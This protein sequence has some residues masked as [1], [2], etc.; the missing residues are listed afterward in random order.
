MKFIYVLEDDERIQKDLFDAL[1]SID[2]GLEIRFFHSLS[3]FHDWLKLAITDGP[4][5]L[6]LGG[7]RLKSDANA[8][9]QSANTHELRLVIAKNEFLGV[10]NMGL[11][12]R[13]RDFFLRKK[14]CSPQE[15]T[16]LVLTAFDSPDFDIRLAEQRIINNVIFKPFDKLILR[17]HLE[18][19]LTGH[20]PVS[21]TAVASMQISST[22]EM[23]KDIRCQA[24]TE[25]GFFTVNN[26]EIK[27]GA[28]TKYYSDIFTTDS[29]KSGLA[30]CHSCKEISP[31]E[32]HCEFHFFGINN[33]QIS[34]IRRTVLQDKEHT[35]ESIK[36]ILGKKTHV[37]VMDEDVP[38]G[39]DLKIYLSERFENSEIFVYSN[40]GQ[41]LADLA[42]KDTPNKQQLPVSFDLVLANYAL[43]EVEK[44]KK[45]EQL[46]Q[47]FSDRLKT[48]GQ[49]TEALPQLLL[50][51]KKELQIEE[52]K[53]IAPW[54]REVFFTPLDK[55]YITKKLLKLQTSLVNK[56]EINIGSH[57]NESLLK[58]AN[59]VEITQISEAG[60]IMKYYREISI[61]SFREFI[62]W[63]PKENEIPEI[64]G[65]VNFTEKDLSGSGYFLNH[66]VFFGM[67]DH[68]L[69]HIRL[70]L[71][72]AY[73][74]TKDR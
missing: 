44:I 51:S 18:Y 66:F 30:Y 49:N 74:K 13:A 26:H 3:S 11:I 45:W 38:L 59:P 50:I 6:A 22:I 48:H 70:W 8:D 57:K 55:N 27:I 46:Q 17:Q 28:L 35:S 32:Y 40:Y 12:K 19:A 16:A 52:V 54:C 60:L 68:F 72:E 7:Q 4:K 53:S 20:H 21:T 47:Y 14:M 39:L 10:K 67:R 56:A 58:V 15:P 24:L 29:K 42:D 69:K 33:E 65:T 41:L 37:L 73:I 34:R 62:L 31:K 64:T 9:V 43:F 1:K 63:R 23:L 2:Q 25:I 5:A 36:N 71:R 61:G